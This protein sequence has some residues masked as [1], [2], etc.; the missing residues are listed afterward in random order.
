[1]SSQSD[2]R[3]RTASIVSGVLVMKIQPRRCFAQSVMVKTGRLSSRS[4]HDAKRLARLVEITE[5]TGALRCGI[6]REGYFM[7]GT[8][9]ANIELLVVRHPI[10]ELL[11]GRSELG[12]Q[13]GEDRPRVIDE[14][15]LRSRLIGEEADR[16]AVA[17]ASSLASP[18]M[19]QLGQRSSL[20]LRTMSPRPAR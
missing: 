14:E 15:L 5:D 6:S 1:M 3:G 7:L 9:D 2:C 4:R 11:N 20:G 19:Y 16:R 18:P 17:S 8:F 13:V 10:G 12:E